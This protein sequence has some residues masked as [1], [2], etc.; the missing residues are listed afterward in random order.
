MHGLSAVRIFNICDS[1]TAA[2]VF[3]CSN[4]N[5]LAY[6]EEPPPAA[7]SRWIECVWSVQTTTVFPAHRVPPDGCI[8]FVFDHQ[9]GLRIAGAMTVEQRFDLPAQASQS[10]IRFRPGMA[11]TF[12][13]LPPVEVTDGFMPVATQVAEQMRSAESATEA[14][15]LLIGSLRVPGQALT[16]VQ[17]AIEAIA[18]AHGNADLEYCA[19]HANL[20]P[21]QFRRR[22]EEESGL[23]PKLLSRILRFRHASRL[24]RSTR[25]RPNWSAVAAEAGTSTRRT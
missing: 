1:H 10:G 3:A 20:S 21:R 9:N 24:A 15:Q 12:L 16:P 17:R 11:R 2:L 8:D 6:R 19:R 25:A 14:M 18:V 22:C 13:G 5:M 23:S 4:R 7:L